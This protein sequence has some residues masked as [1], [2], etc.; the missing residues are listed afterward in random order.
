MNVKVSIWAHFC[1][2]KAFENKLLTN[3]NKLHGCMEIVA[4]LAENN[5]REKVNTVRI[6]NSSF[7]R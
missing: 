6:Q 7:L 2:A 4:Y 5:R 3:N 1:D